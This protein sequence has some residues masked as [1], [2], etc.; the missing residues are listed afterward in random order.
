[1]MMMSKDV[2]AIRRSFFGRLF[3]ESGRNDISNERRCHQYGNVFQDEEQSVRAGP[4]VARLCIEISNGDLCV[5]ALLQ[6][7][8]QP[9]CMQIGRNILQVVEQERERARYRGD[10]KKRSLSADKDLRA[11]CDQGVEDGKRASPNVFAKIGDL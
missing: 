11:R 6:P 10:E 4:D 1:M 2:S 9:P 8:R 3:Q 7:V 5:A